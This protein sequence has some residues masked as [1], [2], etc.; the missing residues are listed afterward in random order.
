MSQKSKR[1]LFRGMNES[2]LLHGVD[3]DFLSNEIIEGL[4]HPPPHHA[5][6]GP[7]C[8]LEGPAQC[9]ALWHAAPS[10]Y[11]RK[12]GR[13]IQGWLSTVGSIPSWQHVLQLSGNQQWELQRRV[14]S[15][16]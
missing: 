6:Y 3:T 4:L 14:G 10:M 5:V 8:F 16:R 13:D 7:K 1:H 9:G 12:F 11:L 15:L 2:I